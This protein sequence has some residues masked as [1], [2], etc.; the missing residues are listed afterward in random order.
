MYADYFGLR[1]PPFS[2][3]PD[4]AYVYLSQH[5]REALAHLL[6][7]TDENGGFVQLTGEVGTGKTT[8]VRSLLEQKLERV[9]IALCLNPR[10][11][12]E[13]LLATV[14]D[15]LG[16]AYP[17]E[18]PTLK[19]L[20][21]AL[22]D[23]LLRVHAAGRRT[24]L[25]IDEAQN[26]SREVLEQIRLLTNLETAKHKLLRIILVGQPELRQLLARPDLRQLA[27][28][29]TARYHLP[30]LDAEDAAAYVRHR[31]RVAGGREDLFS[32]GALRAVH[33]RSAGIPR[34][35]NIIC[36]RA[37]LGAYG[38]NA[39]QV[40]AGTVRQAAREA[41]QARSADAAR[42]PLHLRPALAIGFAGLVM[43]GLGLWLPPTGPLAT[44]APVA[45]SADRTASAPDAA[46]A[47]VARSAPPA[48]G[49]PGSA[50]DA[51]MAATAKTGSVP[52]ASTTTASPAP[53][54]GTA[55]PPAPAAN[56][57]PAQNPAGPPAS[58]AAPPT[59][60]PATGT[61]ATA[62]STAAPVPPPAA[63]PTP[64]PAVSSSPAAPPASTG[65]PPPAPS[66]TPAVAAAT[67]L[68]LTAWLRETR[69]DN[70]NERLLAAWGIAPFQGRA[71]GFCEYVKTRKLRCLS[72]QGDW[73]TL[74]R[75]DRP[76]L[77]RLN[78]PGGGSTPVLLRALD[79]NNATL[80]LSGQAVTVPVSQLKPLWAGQYVLLWELQTDQ[81]IIGPGNNGEAVRWLRRRLAAAAG[82]PVPETPSERFDADLGNEVRAFQQEH[83]LLVDGMA[84]E[85]TLLLLNN[86]AL[87]PETPRL[88]RPVREP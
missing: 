33:Q 64:S 7:G 17:P 21:D 85:Q 30:A 62:I 3:T 20:V 22:N 49:Q 73:Q 39:K 31:L 68:D 11:T 55:A 67:P 82:R 57:S 83:G 46:P 34:L 15:E 40:N 56:L 9:D 8:L 72:G 25:I 26:L 54:P 70:G 45:D 32:R 35:I 52:S 36:D 66:A 4:P 28:R 27:Q 63:A 10:L 69:A 38:Q 51:R 58:R 19:A 47:A 18:H 1:E 79:E 61:P 76:T 88:S 24:V 65:A 16:V 5:H 29:I 74:R 13:E 12:V 6:Y 23:H 75:F 14:C 84:G 2:I 78:R 44:D 43:I 41:L 80:E 81:P 53:S 42:H 87:P 50:D 48:A 59:P 71:A 86:L 60:A 37:L 77:L